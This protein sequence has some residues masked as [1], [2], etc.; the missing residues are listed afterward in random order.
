MRILQ[1]IV[2]FWAKCYDIQFNSDMPNCAGRVTVCSRVAADGRTDSFY[3]CNCCG[4]AR[5]TAD[6]TYG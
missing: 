2:G 6:R 1:G 4:H 3:F 5:A